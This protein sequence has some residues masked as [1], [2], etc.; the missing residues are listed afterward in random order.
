MLPFNEEQQENLF[1]SKE[2][3]KEPLF[4]KP[5]RREEEAKPLGSGSH[6]NRDV[7]FQGDLKVSLAT[8]MRQ[9]LTIT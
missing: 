8:D 9:N 6:P 2:L 5:K 7:V 1:A 4:S 3:V